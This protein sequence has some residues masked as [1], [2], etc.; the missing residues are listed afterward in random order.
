MKLLVYVLNN[1]DLL[2]DLLQSFMKSGIKGATIIESMGMARVLT[3][4]NNENIPLIGSLKLLLSGGCPFNKTIFVALK[5]EQVNT[6]IMAIKEVV[7][8]LNEPDSGILFTLPIDY[9]EGFE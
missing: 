2:D 4:H 1:D 3:S 5:D 6:C 7:G 9:I 8:S